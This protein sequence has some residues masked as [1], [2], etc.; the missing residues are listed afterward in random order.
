MAKTDPSPTSAPD[1]GVELTARDPIL[2]DGV[3]IEPGQIFVT[4]P[5]VAEALIR[6]GS[7]QRR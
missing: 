4:R 2:L 5:G 7:A 3:R 6:D 1:D